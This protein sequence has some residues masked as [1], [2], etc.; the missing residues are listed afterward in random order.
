MEGCCHRERADA[1][2]YEGQREM[3]FK[4]VLMLKFLACG[5]SRGYISKE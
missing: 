5:G 1:R 4:K 3:M 2:S